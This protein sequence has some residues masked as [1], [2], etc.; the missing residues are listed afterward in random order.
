MSGSFIDRMAR[1]RV[2]TALRALDEGALTLHEPNGTIEFRGG[3]SG[4]E[5]AVT[6]VD[7]RTYRALA[8]RGALG[9]A[10]AFMNGWWRSDD[11]VEVVRV[12]ARNAALF[13]GI[14][15]GAAWKRPFLR[16]WHARRDNDRA[17]SRRNIHEHYDLGNAFFSTFLDPSLTYSS[18][19]F[20]ESD[21]S[22][23]AAQTAKYERLCRKLELRADHRV[24]E[25]GT[26]WG[27]FA[28]HAAK[29]RGCRVTTATI[30]KEQFELARERIARAGLADRVEVLLEDYRDL[31]GRFDR[32]VS[33]EM[34]EAVGYRYVP[35]FFAVCARNLAENGALA[36]QAILVP[37]RFWE[38]SI[39]SV[40]F[41]KRHVFPGGQLVSLGS[42]ARAL[43]ETPLRMV[44]YEDI[45]PHYAETLRRWRKSYLDARPSV[46]GLGMD[47]RFM[48][49]WDYYLAYC[50]GA[51]HERVNL[52]AQMIFENAALRRGS[53]LGEIAI[54]RPA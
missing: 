20:E 50:E 1:T 4:P 53:I 11:L 28:L 30:S 19:V 31:R 3:R 39:R 54:G 23:E 8:L 24:L 36:L 21:A 41:I 6:V 14:D 40:D 15:R 32:L 51:F 16:L 27:G 37:D 26:G 46:E 13:G 49:T 48:R 33:I 17:G 45:T 42:I 38:D 5:A 12:F 9:G 2:R 34:I 18:A 10:E 43:A 25:I 52:A 29:T 7:P 35:E 22:L 44:H 47:E